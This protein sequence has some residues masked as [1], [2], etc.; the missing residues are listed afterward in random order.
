VGRARHPDDYLGKLFVLDTTEDRFSRALLRREAIWY[1]VY[2]MILTAIE[3]VLIKNHFGILHPCSVHQLVWRR[4]AVL[5][6]DSFL[7]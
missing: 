7:L 1:R 4:C 2:A 5:I 3:A 6:L